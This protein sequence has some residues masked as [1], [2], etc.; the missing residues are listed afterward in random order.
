MRA[1]GLEVGID[2]DLTLE[3]AAV[4]FD[5]KA[6]GLERDLAGRSPGIDRVHHRFEE[7]LG[8]RTGLALDDV[9]QQVGVHAEGAA[10]CCGHSVSWYVVA[11][12]ILTAN[13]VGT[14]PGSQPGAGELSSVEVVA[15]VLRT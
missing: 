13:D 12:L 5:A 2:F 9:H 14:P 8:D 11:G 7:R 10:L 4:V 1:E 6:L 3:P 15:G